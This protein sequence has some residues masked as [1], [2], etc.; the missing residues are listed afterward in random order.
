MRQ[1]AMARRVIMVTRNGMK[2][3]LAT[4]ARIICKSDYD[5]FLCS[6]GRYRLNDVHADVVLCNSAKPLLFETPQTGHFLV[7][8]KG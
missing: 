1:Q 2:R 4:F 5:G 6:I 7:I 8:S 3:A